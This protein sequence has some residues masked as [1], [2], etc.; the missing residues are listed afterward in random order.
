MLES[1]VTQVLFP[2]TVGEKDPYGL[3]EELEGEIDLGRWT[4]RLFDP[5]VSMTKYYI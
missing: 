4:R 5:D 3:V 1:P 2:D